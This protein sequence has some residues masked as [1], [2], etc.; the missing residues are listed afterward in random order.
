M[1][2]TLR[3]L[4]FSQNLGNQEQ[5]QIH[6]R[7]G[8]QI[9][10]IEKI[11]SWIFKRR[12]IVN[13]EHDIYL[14]RWYVFRTKYI[15]LFIHKFERSDENRG[16]LHDHP[17]NFLV[18]PI[19]RG[20]IEH[21]MRWDDGEGTRHGP[22]V[23]YEVKNRVYPILGTR[24]RPA[25]YRHRVELLSREVSEHTEAV[26]GRKINPLKPAWSLFF[27]FKKLRDWGFWMPEGFVN[28]NKFWQDK[29]E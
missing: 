8:L 10:I 11:L 15:S 14:R 28:W 13:C 1:R 29:C 6:A 26:C 3:K 25:T 23:P 20:Y 16:G 21:S 4:S 27:H 12:D 5:S 19:W 22:P 18:I 2:S 9:M 24:L 17:W 7:N